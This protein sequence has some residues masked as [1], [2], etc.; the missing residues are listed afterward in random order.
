MLIKIDLLSI[1]AL[2]KIHI[3]LDLLA[4]AGYIQKENTLKETYFKYLDI[5]NIE[6]KDKKMWE[7]VWYHRIQSLF[8]MEKQSGIQG[9]A[10]TKPESVDDLAVLNSVIRLMSQEKDAELP[11]EKFARFKSNIQLWYKEMEAAGLSK[12]EQTLLEPI[13][14][15]SYGIC[16]SQEKFMQLVQLP[17]CGGLDLSWADA[18]RKAIAKKNPAAYDKLTIEYFENAKKKDL[19]PAL[20]NYVWNTLIA[21]SKGYGFNASHTLAYSLVAL[22]EMNLAYKYPTIFWDCA[23]LIANSGGAEDDKDED[24]EPEVTEEIVDIYEPEDFEEFEYIDSE[25]K[26]TKVKKKRAK[27]NNYNKIATAI[28]QTRE[29]GTNITPPD[30]NR[31]S[32]TFVPDV[33]NN[34]ILFGLRGILNVG[35]DV[36]LAIINNRPYESPLDFIEKVKPKKQS[37]ISLIKAGAFDSMI[38]RKI[39]MGWY[40]WKTCDKKEN[41]TLQNMSS[42]IKYR[43]LPEEN[44]KQVMARRVYEFNRYLKKICEYNSDFYILDE[45]ACKFLLELNLDEIII[46]ED[47]KMF[48]KVKVWDKIYQK[49]MDIFR[50]W[51]IE[52]KESI[53]DTLNSIIFMED[54]KKYALGSY[55][56]W[57]MEALC[58]YYHEHELINVNIGKYGIVD[59]NKLP[60]E[61]IVDRVFKKGNKTINLFKLSKICGT[62][63]AKNKDKGLVSILTT[64]G[65][66]EVK[67]S[68]EYFSLFD[69]QISIKNPDGTKTVVEKSWFNRGNMIMVNGMRSGDKFVSKKYK[70]AGGGHQLYL[71]DSITEDGD[72]V[73]KDKRYQEEEIND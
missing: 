55:S 47:S 7:M 58:F 16:E 44:D 15:L 34:R 17:E 62:C 30:I 25:D 36:V 9:I 45:R 63:I 70:S 12:A 73:L 2:D 5:Y 32:Y 19:S 69:R 3:C 4:D 71:I 42:L 67:F 56:A 27:T 38:D 49:W 40:I 52:N 39:L 43:L 20:C 64:T 46:I 51:I 18:L 31:S 68:K 28:G 72:L 23:C 65:V 54:W 61:P 48:L 66:V 1:E 33:E 13:L 22:Q 14:K 35:E 29:S 11:L 26:K 57:E 59:F 50:S 24:E 8:Q 10:L 60:E 37:M 6:R 53:K 41:I 21:T